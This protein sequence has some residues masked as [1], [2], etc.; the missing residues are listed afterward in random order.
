MIAWLGGTEGYK[1]ASFILWFFIT[2]LFILFGYYDIVYFRKNKKTVAI[3]EKKEDRVPLLN[4]KEQQ[5][6]LNIQPVDNGQQYSQ[7]TYG[8]NIEVDYD[9]VKRK[10]LIESWNGA[11]KK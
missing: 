7:N 11:N 2:L 4:T 3:V 10:E 1:L 6:F 9:F 5:T 8:I